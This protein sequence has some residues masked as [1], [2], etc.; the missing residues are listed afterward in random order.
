MNVS[1]T[2]VRNFSFFFSFYY[3]SKASAAKMGSLRSLGYGSEMD[4]EAGS[5]EMNGWELCPKVCTHTRVEYV[6]L[7]L[8]D[9]FL[10]NVPHS[11]HSYNNFTPPLSFPWMISTTL[12]TIQLMMLQN[13][14]V[15]GLHTP[16]WLDAFLCWHQRGVPY[17]FL[18]PTHL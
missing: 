1:K 17:W 5:K 13:E 3:F 11:A 4:E 7:P 12:F 18:I 15:K 2:K 6:R 8:R 10:F 9:H 14:W 16:G